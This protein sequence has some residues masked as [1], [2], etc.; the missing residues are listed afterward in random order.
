MKWGLKRKG[1]NTNANGTQQNKTKRENKGN[2]PVWA[3][4]RKG[5]E[6]WDEL[7]FV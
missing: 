5:N 6:E 4:M 3:K 2:S 7:S 1:L